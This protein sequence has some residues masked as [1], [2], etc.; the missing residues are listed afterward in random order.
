MSDTSKM[1]SHMKRVKC[2]LYVG[3]TR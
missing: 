1:V 2:F 3:W